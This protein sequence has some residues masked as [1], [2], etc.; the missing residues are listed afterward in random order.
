[1]VA[2]LQRAATIV[3]LPMVHGRRLTEVQ[4]NATTVRGRREEEDKEENVEGLVFKSR[5]FLPMNISNPKGESFDAKRIV[6]EGGGISKA[7]GLKEKL[8]GGF[9]RGITL[10]FFKSSNQT[11]VLARSF[12]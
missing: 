9:S 7:T 3:S 1:M 11:R 8:V 4:S 2:L 6:F 5:G 10:G 12:R